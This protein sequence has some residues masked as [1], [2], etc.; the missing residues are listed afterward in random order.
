MLVVTLRVDGIDDA[1]GF[2]ADRVVDALTDA[3]VDFT[4]TFDEVK[5][6]KEE[7]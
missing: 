3:L 7:D 5:V 6:E 2:D 1:E 4:W